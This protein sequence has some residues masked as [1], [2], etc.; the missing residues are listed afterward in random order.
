MRA[1]TSAGQS[2]SGTPETGA[3]IIDVALAGGRVEFRVGSH[4]LATRDEL[5]AVLRQL[6][7][8][9]GAIIRVSAAA[10]VGAAAA[11]A[12]A[13]A[14]AGFQKISYLPGARP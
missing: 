8:L 5:A 14:D 10:T 1:G 11:A 2:V 13:C 3:P 9:S 6:P 4:R 12:Q 7:T